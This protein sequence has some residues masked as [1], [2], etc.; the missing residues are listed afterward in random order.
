MTLIRRET[1]EGWECGHHSSMLVF[2][3]V[4]SDPG[5]EPPGYA[6]GCLGTAAPGFYHP[7]MCLPLEKILH[8]GG[9]S[10]CW[11]VWG[12]GAVQMRHNA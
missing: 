4:F 9:E 10:L 8:K 2:C 1:E 5:P 7:C 11:Y 12:S 6:L 3:P